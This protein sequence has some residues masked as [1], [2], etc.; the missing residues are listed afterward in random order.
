MGSEPAVR[1]PTPVGIWQG[2]DPA[3]RALTPVMATVSAAA[4]ASACAVPAACRPCAAAAAPSVVVAVAAAGCG[5]A[6]PCR[7]DGS[8]GF[9]WSRS[10]GRRTCGGGMP[11]QGHG[12]PGTV[13]RRRKS[14]DR[15]DVVFVRS[16]R[17]A[18]G[19][20]QPWWHQ[21]S[22]LDLL[23]IAYRHAVVIAVGAR[24][25]HAVRAG[26]GARPERCGHCGHRPC[27]LASAPASARPGPDR[28]I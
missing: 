2:S 5:S 13:N 10:S 3:Q 23:P 8:A 14:S 20:G 22:A 27:L 24:I 21:D 15:L 12:G 19:S 7:D 11:A 6:V 4:D 26:T 9:S 18:P 16:A 1:D 17:S 28:W 25:E